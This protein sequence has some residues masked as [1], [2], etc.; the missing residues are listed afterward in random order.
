MAGVGVVADTG[1]LVAFAKLDRLDLLGLL[2]VEVLI[3]P[4][5]E[6]E[7]TAKRSIEAHRLQLALG[8]LLQVTEQVGRPGFRA[9]RS[10]YTCLTAM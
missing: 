3:P 10:W 4:A 8:T 1:P 2:F 6:R 7:L 5:V 9:I